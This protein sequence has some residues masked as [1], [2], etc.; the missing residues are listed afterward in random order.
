[1]SRPELE[2]LMKMDVV[3]LDNQIAKVVLSGRMDIA[4]AQAVDFQFNTLC[5]ARRKV[6]V[7]LSDVS[8]MASI[9]IRTIV[10][11]GKAVTNKGGKIVLLSPQPGVEKVLETTGINTVI[12]IFKDVAAAAAAVS[13]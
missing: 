13:A 2:K 7:D 12:P 1:M 11:G 3:E 8:F 4:G 6:I 9:G 10:L 5:G